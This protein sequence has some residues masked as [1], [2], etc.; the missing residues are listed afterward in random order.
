MATP[1]IWNMKSRAGDVTDYNPEPMA[2]YAVYPHRQLLAAK[3]RVY[4]QFMSSYYG[5]I[6]YWDQS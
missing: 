6:P 4:I 1:V 2:L 5:D 3:L